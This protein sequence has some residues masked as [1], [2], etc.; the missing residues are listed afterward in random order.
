MKPQTSSNVYLKITYNTQ[1]QPY[2]CSN[3]GGKEHASM[4]DAASPHIRT[5]LSSSRLGRNSAKTIKNPLEA[6]NIFHLYQEAFKIFDIKE[7]SH[8]RYFESGLFRNSSHQV[9]L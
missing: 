7:Y 4:D 5:C 3:Q 6:W 1:F 9:R 8:T 2:R